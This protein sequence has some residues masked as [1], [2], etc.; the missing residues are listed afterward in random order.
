M[1]CNHAP[2]SHCNLHWLDT[3]SCHDHTVE[4]NGELTGILG[5]G[6]EIE[7]PP[8]G[9]YTVLAEADLGLQTHVQFGHGSLCT[10]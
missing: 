2:T 1:T 5:G 7:K 10:Y 8:L 9:S 3:R 6:S 4:D